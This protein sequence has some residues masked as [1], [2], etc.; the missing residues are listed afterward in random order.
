LWV[1]TITEII[2]SILFVGRIAI[3]FSCN[4]PL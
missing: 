2:V 3:R 4:T 1:G